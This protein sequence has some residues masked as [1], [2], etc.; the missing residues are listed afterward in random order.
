MTTIRSGHACLFVVAVMGFA[1]GC[2]RPR[3]SR[4]VASPAVFG[5]VRLPATDRATL[6][7]TVAEMERRLALSPTDQTAA[8]EYAGALLRLA[9]VSGDAILPIRAEQALVRALNADRRQHEV[10]RMLAGVYLSQH[11]FAEALQEADRALARR[12][13]DSWVHGV[14]ADALIELGRYDEGFDAIDRMNALKPDAASY[15]RASY[16]RELQGDRNGALD[17]MR[18][19]A[20]AT[21]ASDVEAAAWHRTQIGYLLRDGGDLAGARREFAAAERAF[22]GYPLASDGAARVAA[23]TGDLASALAIVFAR[24]ETRPL[25]SDHAFAGDLLARLGRAEEAERQFRLA[26]AAWRADA[27]EPTRLARFMVERGRRPAEALRI[28]S[29]VWAGQQDIFTADA[30]AWAHFQLGDAARAEAFAREALRTGTKDRVIRYHAAA[31]QS[32]L[33][34]R[35]EARALVGTATENLPRFDLVAGPAAATLSASLGRTGVAR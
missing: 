26:E 7:R 22:A 25:A 31:I 28:A 33:G 20:E 6:D 29:A 3:A 13:D 27:P 32:A 2:D 18:M 15:A 21:P 9:R 8:L 35:S 12:A 34:R 23:A 19:A 30:M 14:R 1:A 17:L 5:R 4:E 24:I 10:R 11:R 16:A